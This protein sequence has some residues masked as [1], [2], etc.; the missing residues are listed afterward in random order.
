MSL[1]F[2]ENW[3]FHFDELKDNLKTGDILLVHGRYEFSVVIETVQW[4]PYSHSAMVVRAAD[5]GLAGKAPDLL[6]WES[7][8]LDNLP[9]ILSGQ[10]KTGPMLV[11]LEKRLSTTS[12]EFSDVK[13]AWKPM[14]LSDGDNLGEPLASFMPTVLNATFPTDEE[15]GQLFYDGRYKGITA[16]M[17]KLFCSEL[18]AH[19]LMTLGLITSQY[20]MNAYAPK[21]FSDT[22]TVRLRRR[23]YFGPEHTFIVS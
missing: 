7:N 1:L 15:M 4:S 14:Y 6:L 19:T 8:S 3:Y 23:A 20:P 2:D 9:D 17:D 21:D 12:S 5:V 16:P 22:G 11:D 18:L 10:T 13:F